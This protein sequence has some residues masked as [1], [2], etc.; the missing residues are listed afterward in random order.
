MLD[1]VTAFTVATTAFGTI[2]K[3]VEAGR[4]VEDV[5]GQLGKW[6][7]AVSDFNTHANLKAAEKPSLFRRVLHDGSVEQEAMQ[8]AMH[9]EALRKQEYQLKLLIIGHYGEAV[10]NE[11]MQD[12][13]RIRRQREKAEREHEMRRAEFRATVFYGVAIAVCAAILIWLATIFYDS[14]NWR[15]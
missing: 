9:R 5:A 8:V 14:F 2:K 11:M 13:I 15:S 1:P 7:G 12:R 10:Y 4:E 6:F 3:L